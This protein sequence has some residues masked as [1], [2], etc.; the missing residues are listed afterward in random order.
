[1]CVCVVIPFILDVRLVDVPDGVTQEEGH[2]GF[3]LLPSAVLAL[4]FLA[5]RIQP[6]LS[7]VDLEVELCVLTPV[8]MVTKSCTKIVILPKIFPTRFCFTFY[9]NKI[10]YK[11][12]PR[13]SDGRKV[14]PWQNLSPRFS[15]GGCH[16][17]LD[18]ARK[19]I[20]PLLSL[21]DKSRKH[22]KHKTHTVTTMQ[23]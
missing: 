20:A 1:M 3:L 16:E 23:R 9:G 12:F 18:A 15:N 4:I 11:I 19:S 7:L 14:L 17:N 13:F 2:T 5:R 21:G 10:L 8:F 6:F 22:L